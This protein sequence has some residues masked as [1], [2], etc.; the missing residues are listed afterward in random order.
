MVDEKKPSLIPFLSITVLLLS[1][2]GYGLFQLGEN[3]KDL[4]ETY[5]T[6]H[7]WHSTQLIRDTDH[8]NFLISNYH[9]QK[10]GI[11]HQQVL[12]QF[13]ILWSRILTLSEGGRGRLYL[14]SNEA[15]QAQTYAQDMLSE[16]DPIVAEFTADDSSAFEKISSS[17]NQASTLFYAAHLALARQDKEY[18]KSKAQILD[19]FMK[20]TNILI[21]L[22]IV[23]SII[24]ISMLM[25]NYF[26][27]QDLSSN[28]EVSVS[29]R[30]MQLEKSNSSL[31]EEISRRGKVEQ[32][33]RKLTTAIEQS[34]V[35]VAILARDGKIAYVNAK[36]VLQTGTYPRDI[37]DR[38]IEV[39]ESIYFSGSD[40]RLLEKAIRHGES[41]HGEY[42][43]KNKHGDEFWVESSLSPVR[44]HGDEITHYIL[45]EEDVSLRKQH[46]KR[47]RRQAFY[48]DVTGLPNRLLALERLNQAISSAQRNNHYIGL[49]FIDLDQ[50]KRVNDTLGHFSGDQL[51]RAAGERFSS[52]LRDVDTVARLGGDEFTIILPN[53]SSTEGIKNVAEKIVR[54][55][56][57]P[58]EIQATEIF[59]TTSI[60]ITV[61]PDDSKDPQMLMRCADAAMYQ[62]KETGRDN[63]FF[64]TTELDEHVKKRMMMETHLRQA[65]DRGEFEV[66]YQP[67]ID[68]STNLVTGAEALIRWQSSALGDVRPDQFIGLAEETGLI[69][70]IGEWVMRTA[71]LAAEKW[72]RHCPYNFTM[73]VNVS[74]RQF[75]NPEF[76]EA[77]KEILVET[78]LD[79]NS[80]NIE[81][82]ESLMMDASSDI[83]NSLTALSGIGVQLAIDD[84]GTGYS[85]LS[86]V[87]NYPFSKLKIDRTFIQ[88]V[89]T[90]P[91]D[92]AL[93]RAI[94]AMANSMHLTVV[95][96][97]V[98]TQAQLEFLREHDCHYAQGFLFSTPLSD[99]DFEQYLLGQ[100]EDAQKQG[101]LVMDATPAVKLSNS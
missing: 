63:Y 83:L 25:K 6:G 43:I 67:I 72:N 12:R 11:T 59:T 76:I 92:A 88:D 89:T 93:A 97:G 79:K 58:F 46:E 73:A 1:V 50:F 31:Q 98:E 21:L 38:H 82:T 54:A 23:A 24:L 5:Q 26:T 78:K 20:E 94:L 44:S 101:L 45:I 28:L 39:L 9:Y 68:L 55:F 71:C 95:G 62:V 8:F 32:E 57:K 47:L 14:K 29:K 74:A 61:F 4:S 3:E 70:E 17:I 30:T 41:W 15:Q 51:L 27:L 37:I 96:E 56:K 86:Y 22:A 35:S 53:I 75:K 18:A 36:F 2:L 19:R 13:D 84:F 10:A 66:K 52:L 99:S 40:R 65:L 100:L 16:L 64:Y 81:V 91:E 77:V 42:Q 85:S 34:P 69:V 49:L 48:D 33:L 87:K 7:I 90:D 60:G 80:L